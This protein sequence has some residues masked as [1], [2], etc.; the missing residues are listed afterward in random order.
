MDRMDSRDSFFGGHT[1]VSQLYYKTS[2]QE[3]VNYVDFTSLYPWVN[4]YCW[5]PVGHPTVITKDFGVI[6]DNFGIAKVKI[7][8]PKGMY[9]P[10][11]PY[12][13]NGKLKFPLCKTCADM[14][15]QDP[16]T[17]SEEEK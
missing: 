9:H 5:Y 3:Q 12:R 1:N 10:V 17:C 11:L 13:S 4:K 2:E 7:L 16:C 14:E 6:K 8:L 15:N